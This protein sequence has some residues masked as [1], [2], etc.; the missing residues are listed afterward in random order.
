M[1]V[2]FVDVFGLVP[3]HLVRVYSCYCY[4]DVV[5]NGVCD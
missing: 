4:S 1:G 2:G 5:V 3:Q